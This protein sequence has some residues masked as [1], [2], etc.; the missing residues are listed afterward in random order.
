MNFDKFTVKMQN[1]IEEAVKT[2]ES[3]GHSEVVPAHMILALLEQKDGVLRPLLEK[4]GVSA[5]SVREAMEEVTRKLPKAFGST[6][7]TF[8]RSMAR[9]LG[10]CE[11]TAGDFKDEYVSAEHFLIALLTDECEEKDALVR[12]GV[13]KDEVLEALKSIRGNQRITS[14][15]PEAQYAALDKYCKDLTRAAK[16][17]SSIPSSEET[18]R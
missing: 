6:Q 18:R 11:K 1:A 8:S 7:K 13:T 9:I 2:A 15:D 12:L 5:E 16:R 14:Q 10:A 3:A 17:T 4:L